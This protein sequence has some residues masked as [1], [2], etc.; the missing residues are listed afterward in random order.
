MRTHGTLSKWTEARGFGFISPSEGG[1]D[2]F[3]HISSMP[4]DGMRPRLG[5]VLSYE[6]EAG[7]DGKQ[8]AARVLRPMARASVAA[9]SRQRR[10]GNERTKFALSAII[11]ALIAFV[12][13]DRVSANMTPSEVAPL[14]APRVEAAEP[15]FSCNGRTRC[16]QM[17][18]C[19]EATWAL[20]HCP[21]TEMD[22]DGD[23]V[24]CE[25][26]WCD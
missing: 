10:I 24:P 23:G 4:R 8:R 16:P 6:V 13:Y 12:I 14:V 15:S 26:Q 19:A 3:V 25:S 7:P 9:A 11:V 5:E 22:G 21:G 17:T 2:V 20:Q 1:A 18:S